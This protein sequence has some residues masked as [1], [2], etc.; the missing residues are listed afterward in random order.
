MAEESEATCPCCQGKIEH[1]P[2]QD[3]SRDYQCVHCGWSEHVPGSENIAAALTLQTG[4]APSMDGDEPCNPTIVLFVEGG[5][6]QGVE[7]NGP[8]RAILCDFD[9]TDAPGTVGGRPCHIGVWDSPEEPSEEF[10]EILEILARSG[11][12][13]APEGEQERKMEGR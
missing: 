11:D 2:D 13:A 1:F 10:N 9:C 12:S 3:G 8:V 7:G 5:A 6:V 4:R